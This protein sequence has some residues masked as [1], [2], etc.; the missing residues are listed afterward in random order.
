V[1]NEAKATMEAESN[2]GVSSEAAGAAV[3][4]DD[5]VSTDEAE[6]AARILMMPPVM[7]SRG[8]VDQLMALTSRNAFLKDLV[9]SHPSISPQRIAGLAPQRQFRFR[10]TRREELLA[11]EVEGEV[12]GSRG[13]H[14]GARGSWEE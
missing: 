10:E 2:G 5:G 8:M 7:R 4:D 12:A 6:K 3:G 1:Q 11:L 13:R 9:R 14:G